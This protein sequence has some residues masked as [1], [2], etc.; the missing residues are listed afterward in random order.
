MQV[1][2]TGSS[3]TYT[4]HKILA[5]EADVK[6]LSDDINDFNSRY[7]VNAGE[8]G[9]NNDEGDLVYDTSANKMK[10]YDGSSW[11]EVT[12][13]GDFKYLVMTNAGTTNAATLNGSNV[14]FDLKE[15]STGGSAASVSSA[16]QLMVSV[17]GVVQKPNTG[18]NPSG[19]DGFVMA[20]ADTITFCA[21]PASGDDIFIIQT[22]SAVTVP[23]PGD[24]TVSAAKIASGA[25]TTAKIADDAVTAAKIGVLDA[26]LQLGDSVKAQFG[27]GNDLS[28]YHSGSNNVIQCDNGYQLHI[29]KN[30]SENIAKFKPDGAVELFYDNELQCQTHGAGLTVKTAGD[31]D[32]ELRITGPEGRPA[33]LI[34]DADDGDDNADIWRMVSQTDNSYY[35]QNYAAGSYETNI[36]ATGNADVSLYYDNVAK[37]A[38]SSTGITV[39]GSVVADNTPGRNLVGNG[40]FNIAQRGT[41][42]TTSGFYTVD[43]HA[44]VYGGTDEAPTQSQHALTSSDSGP[45][46]K[47]FRYSYHVTNGNQT[48]GAGNSDF[49]WFRTYIEAQDIAGSGWNYNSASSYVTLSFWIKS[50]VAQDFKGYIRTHDGTEQGYPFAT[51]ALSANTWTKVTKTIPGHANITVDNND[52]AGI[53]INLMAYMGGTYTD[54]GVTENAWGA[55]SSTARMQDITTTWWTTNDSTLEITGVQL[56]VGAAATEYDHLSHADDLKS[57]QRYCFKYDNGGGSTNNHSRFPVGYCSNSS[58]GVWEMAHPPMRTTE[59]ATLTHNIGNLEVMNNGNSQSSPTLALMGDGNSETLSWISANLQSG[60]TQHS[61]LITRVGSG[62]TDWYIIVSCEL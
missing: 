60:R 6:Q 33:V 16:A 36:K 57:C 30:T 7:R 62:Q 42:S 25:V 23:T 29:N 4:Y 22:G 59:G 2:S 50:S 10:V 12:S 27:A 20:D 37:L 51:G 15:T 14:T 41:T 24:G 34:M 47:G 21:A 19:L 32:S 49:I 56:E 18:T 3:H 26:A 13:T 61:M 11:G 43:R 55:Y 1:S 9:S 53:S 5:K 38:T 39:T 40:A 52:G 8:P 17:N 54:S 35:L 31:T 45:W 46:E 58:T 28:I 48:S 44:L